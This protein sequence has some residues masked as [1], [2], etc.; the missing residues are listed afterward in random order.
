MR[1]ANNTG[2]Y[3]GC[4]AN[5]TLAGFCGDGNQDSNEA[6]DEG[7]ANNTGAYGGCND[8]C[9]LASYCGDGMQDSNES[10]DE[11][12][13]NNTGVYGG[14]NA[15]CTLAGFAAM[16]TRTAMKP[17]MRAPPTTRVPAAAATTIAQRA[18]C[19]DGMQDSNE[20]CDEG[21]ANNTGVYGGCNANC[22]LAGFCGD[23]NQD[24][25]EECDLGTTSN[26]GAYGGCNA[27]CTLA[28]YCG[29]QDGNEDATRAQ[30]T[31]RA[32]QRLQRRLH[33]GGLLRRWK[34]RQLRGLRFRHNE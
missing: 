6:C 15:N 12:T 29:D 7:T 34:P 18:Y 21:T 28:A 10:C 2:V 1:T 13:A 19:G 3:G 5:C 20:S 22:T 26:T 17:A 16:E 32:V 14:C 11:G 8:D 9:T 24:S 27:Y 30:S 23:G 25:S 4:N 31:T 33:F